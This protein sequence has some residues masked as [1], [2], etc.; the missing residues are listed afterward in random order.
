MSLLQDKLT[1]KRTCVRYMDTITTIEISPVCAPRNMSL[2]VEARRTYSSIIN[3][4]N[5]V[6][7][8]RRK[9]NKFGTG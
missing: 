1:P 7:T 9:E 3:F 8:T 5:L 2:V 6:E 4:E